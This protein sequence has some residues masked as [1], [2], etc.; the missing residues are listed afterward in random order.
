MDFL[1]HVDAIIYDIRE[2]GGGSPAMVSLVASYLFDK[3]THL[4]DLYERK[5]DKTTE[6]WTTEVLPGAKLVDKP[7]FVLTANRT[8]SGAEEFAYDLQVAK[9][10]KVVGD[11]TGGGA[12][13]DQAFDLGGG[14]LVFVPNGR[15]VNPVTGTNWEGVGIT[16]DYPSLSGQHADYI[17]RALHDYKKGGRTNP[18]MAGM[19]N[20]LTDQD[21]LELAHFYSAKTPALETLPKKRFWFSSDPL[22]SREK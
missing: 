5:S 13:P 17:E 19:A 8:F 11:V 12:N 15:A 14:F 1:A 6:Y 10:A 2:N 7:V 3:R 21:I 20:S 4:N 22:A 18:I 16:P 9:R